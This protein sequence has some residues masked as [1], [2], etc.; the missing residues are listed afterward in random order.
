MNN[1]GIDL[2]IW[3]RLRKKWNDLNASGN[4]VKVEFRLIAD[5]KDE[6]HVLIIDVIQKINDETV[7]ETVQRSAGEADTTLGIAGL[8]MERLVSVLKGMMHQ[9][10]RQ[11]KQSEAKL[12]VTMSPSSPVSGEVKGILEVPDSGTKSVLVSYRYYYLL[13]ALRERMIELLGDRWSMVKAVYQPDA[14]EFYFEY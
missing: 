10:H 3:E 12:I 14:L 4:E 11:E 7:L 6:K 9:T 1:P 2:E 8:S 5:P 13:N